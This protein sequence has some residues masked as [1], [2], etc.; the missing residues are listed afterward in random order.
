[1][2]NNI[3]LKISFVVGFLFFVISFATLKD[4]GINWD[5]IN[6]LPRGQAY[7]HYFLTGNRDYS[8][9]PLHFNGWQKPGQWY[10]QDPDYLRI[11]TDLPNNKAFP[12]SMYQ[13]EDMNLDYFLEK[14]GDGHPPLSD[15]MSALFNE[16]L[17]KRLGIVNDVDS[18][19]VYGI[20]LASI[21]V[22]LVFYWAGSLYG[23]AS[24]IVA[25]LAISLYPLFWSESHFNTEKDVPQTAFWTMFMFSFWRGI[26]TKNWKW[27]IATGVFFGLAFGT[28]LNIIFAVLVIVPWFIVYLFQGKGLFT[29]LKFFIKEK[30]I[31]LSLMLIPVI[32]LAIIYA[33]W[34][35]LWQDPIRGFFKMMGFY[36][37]IGITTV[38]SQSLFG[39]NMFPI[40]WIL[41]TTPIVTLLLTVI[42][43]VLYLFNFKREKDWTTG[44]FVLWLLIPILRV[45]VPGSSIY[46]GVRQIME[47]IPAMALV[48]AYGFSKI[49]NKLNKNLK[50]ILVILLF[51]PIL[52]KI[53]SIHPNENVYFNELIGG[54][55]GAK[56][57]GLKY[58]GFS[59][60]SPYR[61]AASW[62]NKNAPEKSKI[63]YTYDLIP[64]LPRIWLRGDLDL[65]NAYRSGYLRQGEYAMGLT[66]DGTENRSY[67]DIY[68]EKFIKPVFEVKV[69]DTAILKIWKNDSD[70]I[71]SDIDEELYFDTI[72]KKDKNNLIFDLKSIKKLSRLEIKYFE[73]KCKPLTSGLV[74]IS[75]DA[76]TWQ[77][78]GGY[79]P[80]DWRVATAGEQPKGGSFIEPFAG[81]EARYI[82]LVLDPVDTCLFNLRSYKVFIFK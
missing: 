48:S 23:I 13:V 19:R 35:Y 8:D 68:L 21:A 69:D 27:I 66:Y 71:I 51:V 43:A 81:Q 76:K 75:A 74:Y 60:G 64:N 50:I 2:K 70:H 55:K 12:R 7:L 30:K 18:Y 41:F 63:V 25:T 33:S 53:I 9:L 11:K 38:V 32:G 14:D 31:L 73:N 6:H 46:G 28:K 61:Q 45:I 47:F 36:Q 5:T 39:L 59:F 1:M 78:L 77:M 82:K 54:L 67:Y 34:P 24:G 4:Y 16:V 37:T 58:W 80:D 65:Y 40:K 72:L 56:E 10:F 42:G 29:N 52:S 44:L 62:L 26:T 79:L 17:F 49:T 22:G 57:Q 15:I 3:N 20:L